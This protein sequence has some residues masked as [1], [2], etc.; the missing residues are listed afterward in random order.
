MQLDAMFAKAKAMNRAN[1]AKRAELEATIADA[2]A[3]IDQLN[4]I[5]HVQMVKAI[6]AEIQREMT[7]RKVEVLGPFGLGAETAI[8][9]IDNN[10]IVASIDFRP[11]Q[12]NR[13]GLVRLTHQAEQTFAPRTLGAMS[14]L[15]RKAVPLTGTIADLVAEL[16][17]Q[18]RDHKP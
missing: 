11:D 17:N 9:V 2:K 8:H 5:G 1:E 12:E 13:P 18:E 16:R 15:N 6:A 10:D 14:G 3:E 4:W 7:D